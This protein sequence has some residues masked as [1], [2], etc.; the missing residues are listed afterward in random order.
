MKLV[1][2]L[3]RELKVWPDTD[4][5]ILGQRENGS[6]ILRFGI[7]TK[8]IYTKACDWKGGVT[9]SEWQAAV[10]ARDRAEGYLE[11]WRNE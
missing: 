11:V 8:E 9:R 1:D 7:S 6:L 4:I 3:A 5:D 2:I 10:D